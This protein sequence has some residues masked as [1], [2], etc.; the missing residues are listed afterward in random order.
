MRGLEEICARLREWPRH[1]ASDYRT[2]ARECAEAVRSLLDADKAILTFTEGDEPWLLLAEANE[3]STSWREEEDADIPLVDEVLAGASFLYVPAGRVYLAPR[4]AISEISEPI[5]P[6]IL[7]E[8]DEVP[9]L[10][11]PFE[12]EESRGRIF[13]FAPRASEKAML[14]L[15]DAIGALVSTRF[16]ATGQSAMAVADAVRVERDRVARDLHDGLLQ[17]FTGIVL[18][19]ET[20]HSSLETRPEDAQ[21]MITDTQAMIMADQRE[22]RRF[23]EE[24]RPRKGRRDAPFDFPARL[25]DLR[26]RFASQWGVKLVFDVDRIEPFVGAFLGQE[27]FKLIYEAV[28]NAA[29]H[30]RASDVRVGVRTDDSVMRIEVAD[31]GTGFSFQGRLTLDEMREKSLGPTALAERVH[32]LNGNLVVDSTDTGSTVTISVPLGWGGG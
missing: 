19:L 1:I 28:T 21:K 29:K 30:G 11:M 20:I 18:Q 25:E 12:S 5:H 31:N 23:V 32:S 13:V 2:A 16:E 7:V 27:T 9:I 10:S 15:A 6:V 3:E 17:S 8:H 26:T 24:L 22:L 14:S 4:A